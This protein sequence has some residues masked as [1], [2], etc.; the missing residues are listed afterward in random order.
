MPPTPVAAP[1]YGSI[2]VDRAGV[3]LARASED[4]WALRREV[5]EE[6]SRV[7][8]AAVLRPER[9]HHAELNGR[10]LAIEQVEQP[11]VLLA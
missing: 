1:W 8:V 2:E 11:L 4:A 6:R 5:M 9:R 10:G 3:L 7:L